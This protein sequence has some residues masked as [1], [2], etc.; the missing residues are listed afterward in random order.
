MRSKYGKE[1]SGKSP[2][3]FNTWDFGFQ[4]N[5]ILQRQTESLLAQR[6][7]FIPSYQMVLIFKNLK[8]SPHRCGRTLFSLHRCLNS[9]LSY[10]DV[11]TLVTHETWRDLKLKSVSQILNLTFLM[12]LY[13]PV[14]KSQPQCHNW[15]AWI[16]VFVMTCPP[17]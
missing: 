10:T 17:L 2:S 11:V 12:E 8:C 15:N 14:I 4:I 3:I 1:R 7:H 16:F 13:F 5:W 6:N 9:K